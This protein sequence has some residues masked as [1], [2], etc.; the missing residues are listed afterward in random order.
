VCRRQEAPGSTLPLTYAQ[1]TAMRW[2]DHLLYLHARQ[3]C[4]LV[5]DTKTVQAKLQQV[6]YLPDAKECGTF[7][8]ALTPNLADK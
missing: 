2:C 8:A 3:A 1:E 4:G 7:R 6:N 5:C